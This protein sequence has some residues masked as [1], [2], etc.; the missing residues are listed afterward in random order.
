MEVSVLPHCLAFNANKMTCAPCEDSS[1]QSI[2]SLRCPHEETLGPCLPNERTAK[3][4]QN[5]IGCTGH[6]VGF[7]HAAAQMRIFLQCDFR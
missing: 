3:T 5:N 1:V 2:I 4:D 6:F 7:C